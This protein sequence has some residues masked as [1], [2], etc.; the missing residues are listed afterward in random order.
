MSE[1][2]ATL[3]G[4]I[5]HTRRVIDAARDAGHPYEVE[6]HGATLA[7]LLRTADEHSVPVPD[8]TAH[9]THH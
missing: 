7:A 4:R 2:A 1:F 8:P 9:G 6:L 3:L 5:E